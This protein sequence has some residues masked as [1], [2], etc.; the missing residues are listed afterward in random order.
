MWRHHGHQ[1]PRRWFAEPQGHRLAKSRACEFFLDKMPHLVDRHDHMLDL[2]RRLRQIAGLVADPVKDG[3]IAD[4]EKA[5]DRAKAYVAHGVEQQ[6]QGFH[7]RR[8]AAWRRHREVASAGT[9]VIAL[10]PPHDAILHIVARAA[11]LAA[12]IRHGGPLSFLPPSAYVG[13]G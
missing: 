8:L 4:A 1:Q 10:H 5:G 7:R 2:A 6:R 3:D 12:N 13:Y 11:A 9:T